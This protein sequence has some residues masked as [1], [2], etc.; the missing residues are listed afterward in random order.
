MQLANSG[1][2][3]FGDNKYGIR[4]KGKQIALWA[5]QLTIEHPV[6]KETLK[7]VDLPEKI[8]TWCILKEVNII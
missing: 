2:S 5:Y 7:F 1:H 8:G 6:T 4:G 3:I